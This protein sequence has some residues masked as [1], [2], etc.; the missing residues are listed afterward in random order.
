MA[1]VSGSIST[2]ELAGTC[3][4][5][6]TIFILSTSFFTFSL[7]RFKRLYHYNIIRLNCRGFCG[8]LHRLRTNRILFHFFTS[9]KSPRQISA[10]AMTHFSL[11]RSTF[12]QKN[13]RT[14]LPFSGFS[15]VREFSFLMLCKLFLLSLI[16]LCFIFPGRIQ[17]LL[18]P[19]RC[20]KP[21]EPEIPVGTESR[22]LLA[23]R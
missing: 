3:F 21:H 14:D 15:S 13:S 6:T 8:N 4:I 22:C 17:F 19:V 12:L 7:Q 10:S 23:L 2:L 5:H 18:P 11:H 1:P 20:R 16:V 9:H